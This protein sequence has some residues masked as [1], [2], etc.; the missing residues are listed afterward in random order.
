MRLGRL[1][2]FKSINNAVYVFRVI[3]LQ[4]LGVSLYEF[5]R[6]FNAA[7]KYFI[8]FVAGKT[9]VLGESVTLLFYL[10]VLRSEY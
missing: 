5:L 6:V 4:E 3:E 1:D 7:I 8:R 9:V 10:F 2:R